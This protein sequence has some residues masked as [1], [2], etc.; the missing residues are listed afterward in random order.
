M[1]D[2]VEETLNISI[3]G[4][5]CNLDAVGSIPA[6]TLDDNFVW[7]GTHMSPH[8]TEVRRLVSKVVVALPVRFDL[9]L[10]EFPVDE[11]YP[12]LWE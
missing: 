8:E 4:L 11:I 12:Y 6:L 5:S 3:P 9:V 1:R 10:L 2:I 7:V